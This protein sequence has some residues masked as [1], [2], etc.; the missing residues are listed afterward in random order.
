MNS[1]KFRGWHFVGEQAQEVI[2]MKLGADKN[3]PRTRTN[4]AMIGA[5]T[6]LCIAPMPA[7]GQLASDAVKPQPKSKV[8]AP[9]GHIPRLPD[10]H[11][12]LN[13]FYASSSGPD[14]PVD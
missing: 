12:N 2:R 3:L 9:A 4:L 7:S 8:V 6:L 13:G 14:T 5:L 1:V 11:P 10:G